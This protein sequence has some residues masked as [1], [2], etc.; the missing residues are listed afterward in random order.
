MDDVT[1]KP[2][3][4]SLPLQTVLPVDSKVVGTFHWVR[5]ELLVGGVELIKSNFTKH[6]KLMIEQLELT[7]RPIG[8]T[9]GQCGRTDGGRSQTTKPGEEQ[10]KTSRVL[11]MD[12]KL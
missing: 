7:G 2:G 10:L 12:I 5:F 9:C 3:Q 8:P 11:G 1:S 6:S 4:C